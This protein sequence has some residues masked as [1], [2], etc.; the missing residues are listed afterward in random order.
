MDTKEGKELHAKDETISQ[1]KIP[2]SGEREADPG[3]RGTAEH[4]VDKTRKEASCVT[5]Q[6]E[7]RVHRTQ[8]VH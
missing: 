1:K 4:S 7:N 5:L 2:K 3:T 6:F 8:E